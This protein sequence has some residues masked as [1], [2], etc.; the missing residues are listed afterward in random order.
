[1]AIKVIP[2]FSP[3]TPANLRDSVL[4][5][6][7]IDDVEVLMPED[8]TTMMQI[9]PDLVRGQIYILVGSGGSENLIKDFVKRV[10]LSSIFLLSHPLNNSLPAAMETR[11]S[12]E[13]QGFPSRIIHGPLANLAPQLQKRAR[14]ATLIEKIG[15]CK[16]GLIGKSSHWLIA[17]GVDDALVKA[18]W[19]LDIEHLPI[20]ILL[21]NI[22]PDLDGESEAHLKEF[23]SNASCSDVS[24]E[25]VAKAAR[26]A[27]QLSQIV[28]SE[29]LD[30]VTI[31]CFDLLMQTKISGCYALSTLNERDDFVAGCEGDIPSTFTMLLA[32]HLSGQPAFMANVTDVDLES[33][34][35]TF[36]HCTLPTSL[37]SEY[38][39]M[40]HYETGMSLGLRGT[41]SPQKITILKVSGKDLTDYWVSS[42]DIIENLENKTGCRTQIRVKLQDSVSYFLEESL[43]NHHVMI[44]GDFAEGFKDFFSFA[45]DGW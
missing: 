21:D 6:M 32:K 44:L 34:T 15:A 38:R 42:G 11:A 28:D 24:E 17:S 8:Y 33:N 36:A 14:F 25:E 27:Q 23:L 39:I 40:T 37:A 19:G 16:L 5:M 20:E 31:E 35:A 26:V 43:A 4:E 41:I 22:T 13:Q 3:L 1:M 10:S 30:A 18:R 12:L 2:F 45:V 29:H 9:E 7:K